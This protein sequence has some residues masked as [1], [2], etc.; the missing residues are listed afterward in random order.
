LARAAIAGDRAMVRDLAAALRA[1]H[2]EGADI[3]DL[4]EERARRGR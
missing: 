4:D 1:I 2:H 3:V